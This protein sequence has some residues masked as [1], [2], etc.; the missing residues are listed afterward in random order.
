MRRLLQGALLVVAAAFVAWFIASLLTARFAG[1]SGSGLADAASVVVGLGA[2][3]VTAFA[4]AAAAWR[5]GPRTLA[6]ATLVALVSGIGTAFLF[7]AMLDAP[8]ATA[9]VLPANAP[10]PLPPAE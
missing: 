1:S 10:T 9:P 5:A 6:V 4:A 7:H 3:L 8:P 2:A